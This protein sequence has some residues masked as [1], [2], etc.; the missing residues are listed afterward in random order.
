MEDGGN[1]MGGGLLTQMGEGE[2]GMSAVRLPGYIGQF[3]C[4]Q[5]NSLH[6]KLALAVRVIRHLVRSIFLIFNRTPR[7]SIECLDDKRDR[8]VFINKEKI[9]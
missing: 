3:K 8:I 9:I 4:T 6:A 1:W 7:Y 5:Q 2:G